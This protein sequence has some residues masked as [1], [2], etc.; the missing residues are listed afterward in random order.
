MGSMTT[1]P[2][3]Q[4]LLAAHGVTFTN[5][6]VDFP[7]CCPSRA[8]FLTGQAAHNHGVLN[9]V[10]P[11][12]GYSRLL[13]TANNTLPVW[14]QNA[15]YDTAHIGKYINGYGWYTPKTHIP[16]GWTEW[17]G[18]PDSLGVTKYYDYTINEN[19]VLRSYGASPADYQTDVIAGLADEFIDSH[20]TT[21]EPFFLSVAPAAPHVADDG[22]YLF[23]VPAPR[24]DGVFDTLPLPIPPNF[25]EA[26]VSDKPSFIQ[27]LEPKNETLINVATTSLRKRREALLAVDDLVERVVQ[28]LTAAGK[29]DETVIVLT[30]DNG[31][32]HG[33]HRRVLGKGHVYEEDI[34]VPLLLRGP[35]VP[36]NGTRSQMVNNLDLVATIVEMADGAPGRILDGHP[37]IDVVS[38]QATPWRTAFLVQGAGNG[39]AYEGGR[40]QAVRTAN[41][42]YAEH[43][44]A[45]GVLAELELYD[46]QADPYQLE[47]QHNNPAHV[48]IRDSLEAILSTLKTC[49]G[50]SCWITTPVP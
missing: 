41:H 30:S 1:M 23:P 50:A 11:E 17:F 21:S 22:F 15:G 27:S 5:S 46:M 43:R 7:V 2:K 38:N 24:H 45:A 49:A 29:L 28:S 39:P 18:I 13:P 3:T 37:F 35:G 19:G 20:A 6:F 48:G 40:M 12:G 9:N 47:S 33:E 4:S 25:N 32:V 36:K 10:K 42:V 34:R 31:F 44:T 26:D 14:L 16:P 8:S